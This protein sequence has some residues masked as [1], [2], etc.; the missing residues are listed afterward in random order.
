MYSILIKIQNCSHEKERWKYLYNE[1]GSLYQEEDLEKV[2]LKI[3]SLLQDHLLSGI[4]VVAN[5][6]AQI[7]TIIEGNPDEPGV[8][9]PDVTIEDNGKVLM[10]IDGQWDK[11]NVVLGTVVDVLVNDISVVDEF[12]VAHITIPEPGTDTKVIQTPTEI[13]ETYELLFS[14]SAD[15]IEH[16]E[17]TRK[18]KYAT[19]NPNKA[20]F[21]FGGRANGSAVGASSIVAGLGCTA[22]SI[23]DH[24]EGAYTKAT[25]GFSHAEGQGTTASGEA[26][27]AEGL[28]TTSS[29]YYSH[30]E[31][32][33]TV[34]QR[35]Y[36][37]VFGKFN[38]IDTEGIDNTKEGKYVEIVGNGSQQNR[39]N[40]R[41]LDWNGNEW[42]AGNLT[43]NN[44]VISNQPWTGSYTSLK[45]IIDILI[46]NLPNGIYLEDNITLKVG[47]SVNLQSLVI[48]ANTLVEWTVDNIQ[49]VSVDNG[50][51]TAIAN[52][53]GIA[54]VTATISGTQTYAQCRVDIVE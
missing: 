22:S 54:T 50:V 6:R 49:D 45:K 9:L 3:I 8:W 37:H 47:E 33:F 18:S 53:T 40:A 28:N 46:S 26:S 14:E 25:G 5:K 41:T 44:D 15:N 51:V 32:L 38:E 39:S 43:V 17:G 1:D 48:P 42:L 19:I 30:A 12:G 20:A 34:A 2:R 7:H 52:N 21:T 36:Q 24:A 27:H 10:V 29:S 23:A 31:G 35:K 11:G 16:T 13:D 4:K